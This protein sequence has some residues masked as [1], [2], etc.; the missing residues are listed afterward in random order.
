MT[1][2][3]QVNYAAPTPTL[4]NYPQYPVVQN[5]REK[6]LSHAPQMRSPPQ[7]NQHSL[8]QHSPNGQNNRHVNMS[9]NAP[10]VAAET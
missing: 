6:P 10:L 1:P 8:Y 9:V 3:P 2:T 4:I 7:L 5:P